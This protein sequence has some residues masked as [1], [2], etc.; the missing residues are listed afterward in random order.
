MRLALHTVICCC[1][2]TTVLPVVKG[3]TGELNSSQKK[4]LKAWLQTC[5]TRDPSGSVTASEQ[6]LDINAEPHQDENAKTV[7]P[8]SSFGLL[9][10]RRRSASSKS[11]G[12]FLVTCVYHDLLDR[13]YKHNKEKEVKAPERKMGSQGYGRRRRSLLD[14]T[15]LALQTGR[16]SQSTEADQ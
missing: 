10:R 8:L 7:S 1:V 4:R 11:S 13:L 5:M 15:K 2:F 12:C 16:H 3:A 9:I 6:Y 14:V